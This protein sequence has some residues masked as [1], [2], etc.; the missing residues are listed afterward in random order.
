V[1]IVNGLRLGRLGE[2]YIAGHQNL[3]YK[4]FFKIVTTVI[5]RKFSF[6]AIPSWLVLMVGLINSLFARIVRKPPQ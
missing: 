3:S 5:G 2:C 4:D 6:K 1:G